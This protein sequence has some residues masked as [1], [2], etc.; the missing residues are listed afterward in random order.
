VHRESKHVYSVGLYFCVF[1]PWSV[2]SDYDYPGAKT[3]NL[4]GHDYS[5]CVCFAHERRLRIYH[6]DQQT[7]T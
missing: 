6:K 5:R 2:T 1:L 3:F 7:Y 4:C